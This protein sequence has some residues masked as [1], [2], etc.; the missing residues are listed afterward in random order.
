MEFQF[1]EAD[2]ARRIACKA[3]EGDVIQLL[4][5]IKPKIAEAAEL[6]KF[7]IDIV[8]KSSDL[9]KNFKIADKT[10]QKRLVIVTVHALEEHGYVADYSINAD[11]FVSL[12]NC[13]NPQFTIKISWD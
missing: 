2:T 8:L 7:S 6:G 11:G 1:I 9:A 5:W 10:A 13:P 3:S 12:D 4:E